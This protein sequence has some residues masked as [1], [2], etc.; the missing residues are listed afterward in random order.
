[1]AEIGQEK[2]IYYTTTEHV[3]KVNSNLML[4]SIGLGNSYFPTGISELEVGVIA[5]IPS[6]PLGNT[7]SDFS[8]TIF[9]TGKHMYDFPSPIECSISYRPTTVIVADLKIAPAFFLLLAFSCSVSVILHFSYVS[10]ELK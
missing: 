2:A 3:H 10:S 8:G 9:P 6:F 1:M 4:S 7:T 5:V